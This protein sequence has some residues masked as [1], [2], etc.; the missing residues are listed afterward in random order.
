VVTQTSIY[1]TE[2]PIRDAVLKAHAALLEHWASPGTWWSATERFAIVNEVRTAWDA[3]QLSPWVRPS[4]VDGLVADDHVLPAAVVDIIWR[5][6]NHTSTLTRDWYDSFVPDQVS[7]EQY[8]EVLSL[9]S[10][11]NMVD[12][13]ADSLSMDRLALSEP[14]AGEPSRYRPDGVEI[15]RHWVPTAS[16]E[17]THWSPDM[18]M[19][20]PNVRRT[21]NLVPAEAAILW[22]LIDAHYIAGGILSELDSGRNWSIERPHFELLATRTSALNECFY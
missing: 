6:T 5:I 14:R 8:V 1:E 9:V 11:A 17:D 19:E 13:F 20:A 18:P 10:M 16:L 22:M 21:L 2:L 12:R 3:D 4:T 7:A 15:A